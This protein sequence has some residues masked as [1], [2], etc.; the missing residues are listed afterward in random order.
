MKFTIAQLEQKKSGLPNNIS[1]LNTIIGSL[2]E[3]IAE[4]QKQIDEL[5]KN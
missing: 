3:I 4:Q 5:K 2:I 1:E